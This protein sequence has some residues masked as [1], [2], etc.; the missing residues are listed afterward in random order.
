MT[1]EIRKAFLSDN[2]SEQKDWVVFARNSEAGHSR[3]EH[4]HDVAQLLYAESGVML[5]VSGGI[6]RLVPSGA[7]DSGWRPAFPHLYY[8]N[9]PQDA[10]LPRGCFKKSVHFD[11]GDGSV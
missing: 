10:L 6:P 7:L 8:G 4:V 9:A 5:L 11:P 1:S 3:P 2:L